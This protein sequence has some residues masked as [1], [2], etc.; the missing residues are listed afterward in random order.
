MLHLTALGGAEGCDRSARPSL[1]SCNFKIR[2]SVLFCV[3]ESEIIL[4]LVYFLAFYLR[5]RTVVIYEF[6]KPEHF[7]AHWAHIYVI[8]IW[9]VSCRWVIL[10]SS[11]YEAAV[12]SSLQD[13]S[14]S[15]GRTA[16]AFA[17]GRLIRGYMT[18]CRQF[19]HHCRVTCYSYVTLNKKKISFSTLR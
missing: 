14:R 4:K 1:S 9:Q 17:T 12:N 13:V 18:R 10:C 15:S 11:F 16:G 7:A 19:R 2:W 5:S 8:E 6:D 3:H